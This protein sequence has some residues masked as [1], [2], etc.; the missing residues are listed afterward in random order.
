MIIEP[1]H[2]RYLVIQHGSVSDQRHD[3]KAWK[4]AY[5]NS[6]MELFSTIHPV[7]PENCETVLDIGGGLGGIDLKLVQHY[8][9]KLHVS[10]LDGLDCPADVQW[11]HKPFSNAKVAMDFH[12]KN[13]NENVSC[14]WPAP[15]PPRKFDLIVSFAAYCFHIPPADYIDVVKE[16]RHESTVCIFDVRKERPQYLL[17]LVKA[18]GKPVVLKQAKKY[19]RLA[20]GC[21]QLSSSAVGG[22]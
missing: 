9:G 6:L 21:E 13:G 2:F 15:S 12:K 11:H 18:L 17:E 4:Q 5:E 22:A 14:C 8:G 10:I 19:V 16:S 3:L 1:E 20:F 7:L